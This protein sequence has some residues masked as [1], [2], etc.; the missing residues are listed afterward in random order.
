MAPPPTASDGTA[1][2][3]PQP[4]SPTKPTVTEAVPSKQT[5]GTVSQR[6]ESAT[7][8]KHLNRALATT[9]HLS[10]DEPVYP[11]F[12]RP[13]L[14]LKEKLSGSFASSDSDCT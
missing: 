3:A 8:E 2:A 6:R 7:A 5:R 9:V 10:Q 4:F 11:P 13:P 1:T 14:Q 12:S